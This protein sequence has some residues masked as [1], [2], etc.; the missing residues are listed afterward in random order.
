[1]ACSLT[2]INWK[3]QHDSHSVATGVLGNCFHYRSVYDRVRFMSYEEITDEELL[4]LDT[5]HIAYADETH[6]NIG[7]YRGVAL[8][9]LDAN[10]AGYVTD[11]L[12]TILFESSI[13]EFK[14]AKLKSARYRFAAQK[15]VDIVLKW[16]IQ[17]FMRIDVLSWDIEDSRHKIQ[18]RSDI[19]NLRRMYYFL[20]RNVL[21]RRW[22]EGSVWEVYPDES[23]FAAASHLGYLGKDEDWNEDAR[24]VKIKRV[25]EVQSVQEPLVQLADMIAGMTVYSRSSFD[26]YKHWTEQ[27]KITSDR[28]PSKAK[29]IFSGADL[30]RC[31]VI[32]H[33]YE[34][35]KTN[36][37]GVSLT[38]TRGLRTRS[39]ERR[40]NFW[41]YEPQALYDKAPKW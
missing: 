39:P 2:T 16:L 10:R 14:W 3:G 36:K 27:I 17:G 21:S 32:N 38:S 18:N 25:L 30:E 24:R 22:P 12:R 35:C 23:S 20:F 1:M 6:H 29:G 40:L 8:I 37:M 33:L 31:A 7:Q 4:G 41:W 15:I 34:S 13:E 28:Q 19:R 26:T 9:T 5:T 11:C